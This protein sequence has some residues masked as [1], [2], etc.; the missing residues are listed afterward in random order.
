MWEV[1]ANFLCT[2]HPRV[3]R[4]PPPTEWDWVS[5]GIPLIHILLPFHRVSWRGICLLKVH[6]NLFK[7]FVGFWMEAPG[8]R[9]A[10][11][12][13]QQ[14]VLPDS[15]RVSIQIYMGTKGI[16][17]LSCVNSGGWKQ[18]MRRWRWTDRRESINQNLLVGWMPPP[19]RFYWMAAP[20]W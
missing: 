11:H 7:E 9:T 20:S 10:S 3:N 2:S 14:I 1:V 18:T 19:R 6:Y 4:P 12:A 16:I 17:S 13:P 5:T 15:A 8:S